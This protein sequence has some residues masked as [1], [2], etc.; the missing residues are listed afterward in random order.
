MSIDWKARHENARMHPHG[1]E[2]PLVKVLEALS[3]YAL[4]HKERY[5]SLIGEDSVLG[6]QWLAMASAFL[7][8]LN[9]ETGQLDCGTLDSEIRSLA[10]RNGFSDAEADL[11]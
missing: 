7:G 11:L 2:I 6:K 9:G 1:F 3:G 8:L 4:L 10:R 5:G